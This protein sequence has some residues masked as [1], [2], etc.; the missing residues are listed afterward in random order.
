MRMDAQLVFRNAGSRG[1]LILGAVL[2]TFGCA[3]NRGADQAPVKTVEHVDLQRYMGDWYVIANIPNRAE[4]DCHDSIESYALRPDGKVDNWFECRDKSFTAPLE[5]RLN[6]VAT[7]H[8]KSTNAEWRVRLFK[9]I[10][11]KYLV[12]DLDPAYRWAVVGHPSRRYG[13]ILARERTLPE[14][15]YSGILE[16]LAQQGY[17]VSRFERVPQRGG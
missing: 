6:T 13:W 2:L 16:R 14:P 7:I 3:T 4:K 15:T 9:V 11:V 8:D 10:P 1:A 17:D 5:R 12:V